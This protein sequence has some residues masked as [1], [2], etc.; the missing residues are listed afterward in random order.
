[1]APVN[2]PPPG[3][4]S[5]QW[6]PPPPPPYRPA[7]PA[8]APNGQPLA[9]F[10]DRF[11]AYLVDYLIYFV[12]SL[13]WTIPFTIW[14]MSQVFD[15]MDRYTEE[16]ENSPAFDP[17][18][19]GAQPPPPD[20]D[21]FFALYVPMLWFILGT[22]VFVALFSYLYW[23]EFQMRRGGQ[24]V[25]K[26]VMKIRVIPVDP[27]QAQVTRGGYVVR[28]ATQWMVAMVVPLFNLID[29]LWQLWDKPLQQCLHDKAAKS[30][31]VKVG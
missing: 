14:W 5:P 30:V 2:T 11:L 13:A 23:V 17:S 15:F 6:Q 25:G 4:V 18:E 26:R 28:W 7:P 8:V 24:T 12:V 9:S 27:A 1:M 21:G 3:A 29:G 10:Q 22:T 16:L 31:V 20:F 19:P